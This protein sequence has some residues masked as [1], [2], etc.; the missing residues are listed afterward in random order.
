MTETTATPD[1]VADF[2]A[3]CERL[4][5]VCRDIDFEPDSGCFGGHEEEDYE[6]YSSDGQKKQQD[7]IRV[8]ATAIPKLVELVRYMKDNYPTSHRDMM[9]PGLQRI[10]K[11][12]PHEAQTPDS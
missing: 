4:A 5:T 1:E 3:E 6:T 7:E 10:P 11:D 9:I 2:L 12:A 8:A